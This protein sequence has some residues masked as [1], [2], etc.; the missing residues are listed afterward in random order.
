MYSLLGAFK[1]D[2]QQQAAH[3]EQRMRQLQTNLQGQV[4]T[5]LPQPDA[6]NVTGVLLIC[7]LL[8][9]HGFAKC[10]HQLCSSCCIKHNR[11]MLQ[12]AVVEH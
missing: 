7:H 10:V 4:A 11:L 3:Y 9:A 12:V 6:P 5:G 2:F 8:F 1:G